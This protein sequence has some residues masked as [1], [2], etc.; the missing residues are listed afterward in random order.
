[1]RHLP[2]D[3]WPDTLILLGDQV[4]ADELTPQVK[5]KLESTRTST[6]GPS[7][8]VV[9]FQ[10]YEGLYRHTWGATRRSVGSCPPS[11]PR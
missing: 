1:M 3:E 8:E 4:Y 10:E 6:V 7:D 2:V 11:R 5:E 9:S